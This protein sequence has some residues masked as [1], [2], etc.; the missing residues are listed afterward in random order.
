MHSRSSVQKLVSLKHDQIWPGKNFSQKHFSFQTCAKNALCC[1]G[2]I[3]LF[4]W[5]G[6]LDTYTIEKGLTH[7]FQEV[8]ISNFVMC[9]LFLKHLV[10]WGIYLTWLTHISKY[11]S[12]KYILTSWMYRLQKHIKLCLALLEIPHCPTYLCIMTL[13]VCACV[14]KFVFFEKATKFDEISILLLTNKFVFFVS[15]YSF[16]HQSLLCFIYFVSD[17]RNVQNCVAFLKLLNI[18]A[19]QKSNFLGV[20][21]I[22]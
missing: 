17:I 14:L 11:V 15:R 19:T 10:I 9:I 3:G 8:F 12:T 4:L 7:F 13:F 18:C 21:Q 2:F 16:E 20:F 5:I 6:I 22:L 1:V